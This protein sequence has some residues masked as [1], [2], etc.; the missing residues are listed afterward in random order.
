M[1]AQTTHTLAFSAS[2]FVVMAAVSSAGP[3][4]AADTDT[5]SVKVH[6]RDLDLTTDA[7]EAALKQRIA[8]A[9]TNI[10]GPV[11]G[12]TLD[13]WSRYNTCRNTAIASASPQMDAVIASVRSSDHRY[14]VNNGAIAMLGR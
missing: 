3:A 10:C 9:A 8:R 1:F 4:R 2:V 11:G 7:G 12:R 6:Y 13:D 5:T 14:A